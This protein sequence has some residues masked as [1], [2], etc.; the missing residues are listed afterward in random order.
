MVAQPPMFEVVACVLLVLHL[1]R[2]AMLQLK[3]YPLHAKQEAEETAVT[4]NR[5]A[6]WVVY[7]RLG[8]PGLTGWSIADRVV[9]GLL[10]AL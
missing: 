6:V 7:S 9:Q 5:R 1:S 4:V 3:L 8:G 2:P 10:G